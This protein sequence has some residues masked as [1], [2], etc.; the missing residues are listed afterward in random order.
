M[1]DESNFFTD[2]AELLDNLVP[3]EQMSIS[4]KSLKRVFHPP[5]LDVI[6]ERIR[7]KLKG[8]WTIKEVGTDVQFTRHA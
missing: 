3:G 8:H 6:I 2:I 7:A 4:S 1:T 5:D